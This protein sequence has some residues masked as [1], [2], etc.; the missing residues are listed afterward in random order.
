MP[1]GPLL[2]IETKPYFALLMPL[3][4]HDEYSTTV[5]DNDDRGDRV[6]DVRAKR[7]NDHGA[8]K[9]PVALGRRVP[10][11]RGAGIH[12]L[13]RGREAHPAGAGARGAAVP[14]AL[15]HQLRGVVGGGGARARHPEDLHAD[16]GEL[17]DDV[18]GV[19]RGVP[20]EPEGRRRGGRRVLRRRHH[21]EVRRG[22]LL[23]EERDERERHDG[24]AGCVLERGAAYRS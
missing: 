7:S 6:A 24:P 23:P 13:R 15:L 10:P 16:A 3:K 21:R 9:R 8:R 12:A 14:A 1:R 18:R 5:A 22:L 4:R 2:P 17:H 19:Q 11:N 20:G